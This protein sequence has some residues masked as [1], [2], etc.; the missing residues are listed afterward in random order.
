VGPALTSPE[1]GISARSDPVTEQEW[2][3]CADPA[4]MLEYLRPTEAVE[5][6]TGP[7][8]IAPPRHPLA[9]DRKLRLF[10]CACCRTI[11]DVL[12]DDRSRKAIEASERFADRL[13]TQRQLMAACG[14]AQRVVREVLPTGGSDAALVP[15][16]QA[17]HTVAK[18]AQTIPSRAELMAWLP[19][20]VVNQVL[21]C[22]EALKL[23]RYDGL[24][25][26][27]V[28]LAE[29]MGK[30]FRPGLEE[31]KRLAAL[32]RDVIGNPFRP[33]TLSPD[34]RTSGVVSLA[35]GIYEEPAFDRMPILADALEE[36]GCTNP[37]ILHHCRG[38]GP[39]ARGCWAVDQV[40]GRS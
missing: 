37:G 7:A 24:R 40:L 2:I 3:D 26:L 10:A 29:F 36:A 15:A 38:E 20:G 4:A 12:T 18:S 8:A 14:A 25:R 17:A 23:A 31:R 1:G 35:R 21:G 6:P 28:P 27:P 19:G 34:E 33:A 16:V 13:I 11:W 32:L 39:H 22:R 30:P 5:D 9:T